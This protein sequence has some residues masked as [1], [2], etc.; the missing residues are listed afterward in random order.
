MKKLLISAGIFAF[1]IGLS[2]CAFESRNS[3]N[4][5]PTPEAVESKVATSASETPKVKSQEALPTATS[6]VLPTSRTS[7][8]WEDYAPGTQQEIDIMTAGLDCGGIR[9]F[10]GMVTATKDSI[11]QQTGHDS[12][13]ITAYLNEALII[14]RCL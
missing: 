1:A 10:F 11:L 2:G 13:A 5:P 7:V 8:F 3:S 4:I 6:T 14:A 9:T 12:N